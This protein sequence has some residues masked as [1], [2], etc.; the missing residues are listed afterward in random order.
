MVTRRQFVGFIASG[1]LLLPGTGF[2]KPLSFLLEK[3]TP[4]KLSE[5]ERAKLAKAILDLLESHYKGMTLQFWQVPFEQIDFE[6]RITNMIYWVDLA[7]QEH[8]GLYPVDAI[9]VMS[10]IMAESLFCELAISNSLAAGICQFMPSTATKSYQ[11]T[12]AGSLAAHKSPPYLLTAL[13]GSLDEYRQLVQ[14]RN[15]Y[16]TATRS[17]AHFDLNK[18][19]SWLAEGK[20][21]VNLAQEQI[22]RQE[23]L[24]DYRAQINQAR[25]NYV[26][27][28]ETNIT[29]LGQRDIFGQQ[30]F[31]IAFDERFTYKKPIFSMV[32]M[33]ANALRVRNGNILAA[34]AA[35][36]AGLGRTWTNEAIY[37][38]YGLIPSFE[39]TARY[40]SRIVVNYE[41]I[42]KRYYS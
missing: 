17:Q 8:Q 15:T 29:E 25:D 37:T 10:Q 33:L 9:W 16:R 2:A 21:G 34:A 28:I 27:Y 19:L 12:I 24:E 42:A 3:N 13:A 31:F 26:T 32:H 14:A 4:K 40:L 41:E 1:A 5:E 38:Q 30:N 7:I 23:Q 36:N 39:E 18:A 6:K 20:P 35:Y 11:M 22:K